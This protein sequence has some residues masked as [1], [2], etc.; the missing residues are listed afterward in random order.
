LADGPLEAF[1]GHAKMKA[2]ET[3]FRLLTNASEPI[4]GCHDDYYRRRP[5]TSL[6]GLTPG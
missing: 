5:H 6:D 4:A 3:A 2:A 1:P